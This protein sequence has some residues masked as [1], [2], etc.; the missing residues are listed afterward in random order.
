L[1]AQVASATGPE[2][3]NNNRQAAVATREKTI[4]TAFFSRDFMT[5]NVYNVIL[6]LFRAFFLLKKES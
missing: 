4:R 5:P 1:A 6:D 2:N 3:N